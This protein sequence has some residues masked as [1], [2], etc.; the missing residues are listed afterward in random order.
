[1]RLSQY[2]DHELA[3]IYEL[4]A[5]SFMAKHDTVKARRCMA[6]AARHYA[7]AI[8]AKEFPHGEVAN[9]MVL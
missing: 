4:M 1:M 7:A 2:S 9:R 3:V 6:V 8:K 5:R